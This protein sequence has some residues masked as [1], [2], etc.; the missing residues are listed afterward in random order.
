MPVIKMLMDGDGCWPDLKV[1]TDAVINA[2]GPGAKPIQMALLD[3][4]I[5]SG[6]PSVTIRIDLPDGR[7]VLTETS[8]RLFVSAAKAFASRYPDLFEGD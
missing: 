4:G 6:K 7:T 2:M 3:A 1:G 5:Q 8:L